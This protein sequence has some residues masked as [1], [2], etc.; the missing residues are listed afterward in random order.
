MP[1]RKNH[2]VIGH[3][4]RPATGE[5]TSRAWPDSADGA[6]AEGKRGDGRIVDQGQPRARN[7][8]RRC[9]EAS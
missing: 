9:T 2:A 5:S 1:Y 6:S 7:P 8:A 3:L 4:G